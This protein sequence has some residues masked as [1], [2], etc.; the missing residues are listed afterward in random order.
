MS[1]VRPPQAT[2]RHAQAALGCSASRTVHRGSATEVAVAINCQS[3]KAEGG[4]YKATPANQE[5]TDCR[6]ATGAQAGRDTPHAEMGIRPPA[7]PVSFASKGTYNAIFAGNLT[8]SHVV[9]LGELF[10][11]T[12]NRAG[13]RALFLD[14]GVGLRSQ[15]RRCPAP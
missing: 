2:R 1:L 12:N 11:T 15:H 4:N 8:P 13:R 6:S 10:P 9:A 14:G 7:A 5:Q 3:A